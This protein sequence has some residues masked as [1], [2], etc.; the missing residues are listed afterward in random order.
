MGVGKGPLGLLEATKP[1]LPRATYGYLWAWA[2]ASTPE[3]FFLPSFRGLGNSSSKRAPLS[4]FP[5]VYTPPIFKTCSKAISTKKPSF[6]LPLQSVFPL[7]PRLHPMQAESSDQHVPHTQP[8][9]HGHLCPNL[10]SPPA[11]EIPGQKCDSS[12]SSELGTEPQ[13]QC[14]PDEAFL[15]LKHLGMLSVAQEVPS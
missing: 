5:S 15:E 13:S 1:A 7:C 8:L 11:G 2:Y 3:G 12:A 10:P 9:W 6:L 4:P 14:R